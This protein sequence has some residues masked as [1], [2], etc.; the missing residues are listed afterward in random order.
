MSEENETK[1]FEITVNVSKRVFLKTEHF[2][3]C[4]E[5]QDYIHECFCNEDG[6]VEVLFPKELTDKVEIESSERHCDEKIINC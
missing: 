6:E 5:V 1:Y 4:D 3:S 2:E